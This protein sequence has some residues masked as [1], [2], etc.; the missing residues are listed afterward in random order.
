MKYIIVF[1]WSIILPVFSL[2]EMKPNLCKNCKFRLTPFLTDIKYSKCV[3]FQ[4]GEIGIEYF[5]TGNKG[6]I[7]YFHCSTAREYSDMCGK[8]G[9]LYQDKYISEITEPIS[10][11][12]EE[13]QI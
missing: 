9:L 4:K 2:N 11:E 3:L 12:E 5:V 13:D 6:D 10:S 7:D 8:E 1:I